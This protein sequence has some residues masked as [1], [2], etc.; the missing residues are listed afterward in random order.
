MTDETKQRINAIFKLIFTILAGILTAGIYLLIRRRE[1]VS[2]P[3][4]AVEDAKVAQEEIAASRASIHADSDQ[5]LADR[6][7]ALAKK[8]E[9]K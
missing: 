8:E 7:N 5:A 3:N 2:G 4:A 1:P 9:N 6:F